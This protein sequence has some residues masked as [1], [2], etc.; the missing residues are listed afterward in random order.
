M[1]VSSVFKSLSSQELQL[2][3]DAFPAIAVLI[4]G[5][6]GTI[7]LTEKEWA[8]KIVKIRAYAHHFDLKPLFQQLEQDFRMKLD[9]L[10]ASLPKETEAR[11]KILSGELSN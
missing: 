2:I 1:N 3:I 4:S 8:E 9:A 5:A 10:I 7:D 6:D 11:N